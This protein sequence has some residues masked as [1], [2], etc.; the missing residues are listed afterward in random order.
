MN[1]T[2]GRTLRF[3]LFS[4]PL[5]RRALAV[6]ALLAVVVPAAFGAESPRRFADTSQV[7]SVEVPVQ[8]VG[9]DGL[10]VRG[11][12]AGD[13]EIYDEGRKQAIKSFRA[14]D[15]DR[16]RPEGTL[17]GEAEQLEPSARRHLLLLFDLSFARPSAVLRARDAARDLV[18]R[19]VRPTD[20]V[21][22]ATYSLEAGPRLV[23][24]FTPDRAQLVRGILTLGL[25]TAYDAFR[26]DPLRFIIA[27]A[28]ATARASGVSSGP[29]S[30]LDPAMD[31]LLAEELRQGFDRADKSFGRNRV[32]SFAH[33]MA[34]LAKVLAAV[35]GRKQIILFSA[36]FDSR[37]LLG[38]DTAGAEADQDNLNVEEGQAQYVDTDNRFGNTVLQ[39]Q[40]RRMVQ[41]LRRADCVIQAVDIAGLTA[42]G[43]AT[44]EVRPSGEEGLFVMAN[45]TGG[46][47]FRNANDFRSQLE[48]VL[49]RSTV[50]YL[51]SFERSDLEPNGAFRRLKV[52]AKLPAGAVSACSPATRTTS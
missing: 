12:T 45:E 1:C 5:V 3:P 34:D 15:L 33:S 38:H 48:R 9:K 42:G 16:L 39:G 46:E 44:D 28:T 20:L 40:L 24:T 41:E 52:K 17:P 43:D 47:L 31:E 14:V 8:V 32:T 36:G 21:G 50:T 10:P 2:A 23:V 19:S 27:R 7:L 22:L 18:L 13:F 11:L 30:H 6:V 51:L 49:S 29:E 4:P 37:L 26:P 25:D 35:K